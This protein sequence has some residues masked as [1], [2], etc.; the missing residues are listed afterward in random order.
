MT[1]AEQLA[2][3]AIMEEAVRAGRDH[4]KATPE[5]VASR[6]ETEIEAMWRAA[7]AAVTDVLQGKARP[8]DYTDEAFTVAAARAAV[9]HVLGRGVG[10][11][12]P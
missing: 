12:D 5:C 11:G 7:T 10:H 8:D 1:E 3:L 2:L 6:Y 9:A 4:P